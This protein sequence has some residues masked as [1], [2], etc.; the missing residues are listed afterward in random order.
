MNGRAVFSFSRKTVPAEIRALLEET[1]LTTGD[2]AGFL[3]H[4]G[5]RA[6]VD[7]ITKALGVEPAR[8]P[9]GMAETGNL[10]SS[11]LPLILKPI[12][13]SQQRGKFVL[14][15]FGVGLSWGITL[16]ERP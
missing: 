8:V 6:I 7:E 12:L 9:F 13:D 15:G 16:I 4:Q 14:A 3:L 5:S 10:V 1:G 2:V 11:S